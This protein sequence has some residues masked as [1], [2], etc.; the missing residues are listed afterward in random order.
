MDHAKGNE[1]WAASVLDACFGRAGGTNSAVTNER[2]LA[3]GQ[4]AVVCVIDDN[5]LVR[6]T[7]CNALRDAGFETVEAEDGITGLKMIADSHAKVAVIDI[8]MPV[9]E[10][11]DVIVDAT[12]Q[13]P[14]LKV[15]AVS[16]GGV[17]GPTEYLELALQ[18]GAH[19]ALA[20]PFRNAELVKKV[21]ALV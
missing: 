16:G 3:M 5:D 19:D 7:I 15:L 8:V 12:R 21:R 1:G 2:I 6:A 13:F 18:L 9:R 14:D 4:K 11:H 10:G 20:K 17:M